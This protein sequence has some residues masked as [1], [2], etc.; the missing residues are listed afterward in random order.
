MFG[1]NF[2]G[3]ILMFDTSMFALRSVGPSSAN[4]TENIKVLQRSRMNRLLTLRR[5][6]GERSVV[7]GRIASRA[8]TLLAN[9]KSG[10]AVSFKGN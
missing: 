1:I 4:I 7:N 2:G 5:A 3:K 10:K 9:H 6:S 8:E